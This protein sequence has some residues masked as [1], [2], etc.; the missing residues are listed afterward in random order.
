METM[1][2]LTRWLCRP[3]A[4]VIFATSLLVPTAHAGMI[5]T[6][7]AV[8]Q[9]R[10]EQQRDEL[11]RF[12]DRDEV[13]QQL[14]AW[15]VD[16]SDAKARVDR[17]SERELAQM[18]ERMAELPAGGNEIIG[19]LVFVFLVLLFTDILGFTDVFPFVKKTVR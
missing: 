1:H 6:A 19:A 3:L 15:G 2:S 4:A 11:K 8:E 16:P 9:A 7:G 17:L 14:E 10:V 5:G 18:S 13:R 12:L